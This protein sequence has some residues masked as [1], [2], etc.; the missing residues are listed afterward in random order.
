M[1]RFFVALITGLLLPWHAVAQQPSTEVTDP[2]VPGLVKVADS[3]KLPGKEP[4]VLVQLAV[5]EGDHVKEGQV[6]GKI[7]DSEP[8]MQ[9][10]A[11][12][13]AYAAAYNKWKDDVE[14]RYSKAAADVAKA[15]YETLVQSNRLAEKAVPESDLRKAKLEWDKSILGGEKSIHDQEL[16]KYE[17]LSK[18][19]ES[20]AAQLAIERRVV[21]APF[22]G[23]VEEI[24]RHQ[25]EW[26]QPGDTI[27]H[28]L[29]M[30]VL[31]VEGDIEAAKHD[32]HEIQG[33]EVAVDVEMA[34]GRKA[35]FKGRIIKVSSIIQAHGV[36]HVRAEIINQQDHG[37]WLLRDGMP[38]VMAIHLGT[39]GGAP[40]VSRAR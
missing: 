37:N 21:K 16:A 2:V 10:K 33:C 14:I 8:Q 36:F 35:S 32:P 24:K 23:V 40:A 26:V 38:A 15:E 3:I 5:K 28:L 4:G 20:D 11:A 25:D 6:I 18:Q 29:R 12:K 17:A 39:G 30:D 7:D 22:D 1:N 34:R 19:A 31:H 13:A 27:L 9:L